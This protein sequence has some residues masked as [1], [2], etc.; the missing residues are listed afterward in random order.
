MRPMP[1]M[2]SLLPLFTGRSCRRC[3]A[4]RFRLASAVALTLGALSIAPPAYAVH[5]PGQDIA[6]LV[7]NTQVQARQLYALRQAPGQL[8]SQS[9]LRIRQINLVADLE[10]LAQLRDPLFIRRLAIL[11]RAFGDPGWKNSLILLRDLP[12]KGSAFETERELALWQRAF[13]TQP[14]QASEVVQLRGQI[15]SLGLGWFE[16]LALETLYQNANMQEEARGEMLAAMRSSRNLILF[17]QVGEATARVGVLL[18]LGMCGLLYWRRRERRAQNAHLPGTRPISLRQSDVLFIV[19]FS[20]LVTYAGLKSVGAYALRLNSPDGLLRADNAVG[21]VLSL[22]F[23]AVAAFVPYLVYRKLAPRAGI[24]A[25]D[26]GYRSRNVRLDILW[27]IGGY[28]VALPLVWAATALSARIFSGA[29]SSLHPAITDFAS[30]HS[31][32]TQVA[33]MLQ[34]AAVA[35]VVEETL[36]RGVFFRAL[37]ARMSWGIAL[38]ATSAVFAILHPQLPM[39]FLGIFVLGAVFNLLYVLRG[40]LLPAMVAHCINNATIFIFALLV[41]D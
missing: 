21:A 2:R 32:V 17:W 11:Q 23:S 6:A 1:N 25:D 5:R 18:G 3:P 24:G 31:I 40:S 19:F 13:D 37:S 12:T 35:P 33:L 28:A 14:L 41:T 9:E 8:V 38:L 29:E 15:A 27:G 34:A 36:F 26:V 4:A 22:L 20:Y 30:S 39:G 16:H 10:R 7:I